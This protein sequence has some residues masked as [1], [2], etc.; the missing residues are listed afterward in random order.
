MYTS[1]PH[2]RQVANRIA[3][4]VFQQL[5]CREKSIQATPEVCP[6]WI[7]SVERQPEGA[8]TA[9]T[10]RDPNGSPARDERPLS[11]TALPGLPRKVYL[12]ADGGLSGDDG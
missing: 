5:A 8:A 7:S 1:Y 9:Y 4:L 10:G 2:R 12:I 6:G 11:V 3:S